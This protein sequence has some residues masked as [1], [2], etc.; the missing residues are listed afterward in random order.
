[1]FDPRTAH[2][3]CQTELQVRHHFPISVLS[4][5]VH[6]FPLLSRIL[7]ARLL[8][9]MVAMKARYAGK[10]GACGDRWSVGDPIQKLATVWVH[11]QCAEDIAEFERSRRSV[12]SGETYRGRKPSAW[13]RGKGPG[14]MKVP[15]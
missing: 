6:S 14:S 8:H 5:D 3:G 10:C 2:Q 11:G 15:R 7:A 12:L 4:T 13:R 9:G 1:M